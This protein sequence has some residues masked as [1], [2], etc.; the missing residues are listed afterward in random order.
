MVEDR[1]P[2]GGGQATDH[3]AGQL[4]AERP[5][6]SGASPSK[7]PGWSAGSF[8]RQD[9]GLHLRT[10]A[11]LP[12]RSATAPPGYPL[13]LNSYALVVSGAET[14]GIPLS[15]VSRSSAPRSIVANRSRQGTILASA[16]STLCRSGRGADGQPVSFQTTNT[17]PCGSG[18]S[19]A[20]SSAPLPLFSVLQRVVYPSAL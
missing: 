10:V 7:D 13:G 12:T 17:S 19:P 1:P 2:R 20:Q 8:G 11:E 16:G 14:A 6:R 9:R 3:R 4:P 18:G 5:L 15:V